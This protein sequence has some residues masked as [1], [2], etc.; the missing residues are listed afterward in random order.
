M[1]NFYCHIRGVS[2][3]KSY[4]MPFLAISFRKRTYRRGKILPPFLM[5]DKSIAEKERS[6]LP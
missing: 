1:T 2:S 3:L 4:L 5:E 6:L